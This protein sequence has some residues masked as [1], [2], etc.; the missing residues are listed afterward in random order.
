M[1]TLRSGGNAGL[2]LAVRLTESSNVIVLVLEA[3]SD[4]DEVGASIV[5]GLDLFA[6]GID[7]LT[8]R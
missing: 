1:L 3:G 5:P 6:T 8:I 7:P 4:Q 2:A